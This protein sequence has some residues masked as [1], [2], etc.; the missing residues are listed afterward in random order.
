MTPTQASALL[1]LA[2]GTMFRGRSIGADGMAA[3]E[4]VFNTAITGYQ[5]IV[6]DPAYC[7]QIATLT[8]PIIGNVGVNEEDPESPPVHAAGPV[9]RDVP[10]RV[11][12]WPSHSDLPS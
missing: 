8:Y 12:N 10:R 4:V 11:S 2:D 6:T 5:E 1:A 9:V 3:G 7:R